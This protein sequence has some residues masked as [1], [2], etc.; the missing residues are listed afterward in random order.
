MLIISIYLLEKAKIT[1]LGYDF[2]SNDFF[3]T[4]GEYGSSSA[5]CS[6]A[7]GG[8]TAAVCRSKGSGQLQ[9]LEKRNP[10]PKVLPKGP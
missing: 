5:Q 7:L 8:S 4:G 6:P 10:C 9:R 3:D 1:I 2:K